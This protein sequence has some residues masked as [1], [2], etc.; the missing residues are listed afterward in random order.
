M[1]GFQLDTSGEVMVTAPNGTRFSPSGSALMMATWPDLSP[2][3]QGYVEAAFQ[4]LVHRLTEGLI[5]HPDEKVAVGFSALAP[6]T[7]E[8]IGKDCAK[9]LKGCEGTRVWGFAS[10]GRLF[11]EGRQRGHMPA[12]YPPL[13]PTLNDAGKVVFSPHPDPQKSRS[14]NPCKMEEGS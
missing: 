13:T 1:S 4:E 9:F 5:H 10:D 6:E 3:E 2:F 11:W 12:N 8:A 14:P 7:L